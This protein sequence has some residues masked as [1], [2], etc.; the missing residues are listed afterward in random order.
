MPAIVVL[1]YGPYT[2][3][4]IVISILR[5]RD[6]TEDVRLNWPGPL[7]SVSG[8]RQRLQ[9]SLSQ[10]RGQ[11]FYLAAVGGAASF[12][13]LNQNTPPR[14]FS[15]RPL[16]PLVG[17]SKKAQSPNRPLPPLVSNNLTIIAPTRALQRDAVFTTILL[18][19]YL[20]SNA[21]V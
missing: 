1:E 11:C 14:H 2:R 21:L 8:S 16:L 3:R 4:L 19:G 15:P 10:C 13:Y 5:I 7:M 6:L 20:L 17:A 12:V 18:P 9:L